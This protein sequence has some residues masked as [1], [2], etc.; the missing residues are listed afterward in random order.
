MADTPKEIPIKV[1]PEY[2]WSKVKAGVIWNDPG[3]GIQ[4]FHPPMN[5]VNCGPCMFSAESI[6]PESIERMF[7]DHDCEPHEFTPE[8]V[9]WHESFSSAAKM[10]FKWAGIVLVVGLIFGALKI[11]LPWT[12]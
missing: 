4:F 3:E 12:S 7:K 1:T 8:P 10:L 9:L 5:K 2:D 11:Q 6:D